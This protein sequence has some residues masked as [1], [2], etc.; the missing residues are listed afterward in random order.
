MLSAVD[1]I[2]ATTAENGDAKKDGVQVYFGK[3]RKNLLGITS[4]ARH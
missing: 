3:G 1:I 4:P 2:A